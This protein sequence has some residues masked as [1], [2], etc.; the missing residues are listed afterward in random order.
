MV[1]E[2]VKEEWGYWEKAIRDKQTN[3][4]VIYIYKMNKEQVKNKLNEL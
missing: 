2:E 1:N 4:E 3:S